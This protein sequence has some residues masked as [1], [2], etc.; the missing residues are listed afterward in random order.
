MHNTTLINVVRGPIVESSHHG[1]IVGMDF[2]GKLLFHFGHYDMVTFARSSAKLLQA[3]PVIESG[4]AAAFGLTPAEIAVL[5]ASHNGEEEHVRTVSGLLDKLGLS[6]DALQCGAH[7]PFYAPA[8]E[9][10]KERGEKPCPLHNNC[11]GK[12]SGML[13]LARHLG[14]PI[15]RYMEPSHPVQQAM[16]R[17][18]SD[19]AGLPPERILLGTDGCGVPVFGMPLCN[20]AAAYAQLGRPDRLP[21]ER[22]AACR[23][24]TDAIKSHPFLIAG[25]GR[26]DSALIE[27]THGR[28]IGKLGAEGV[29]AIAV[30][31]AGIGI[32][33]K[34]EDGNQR[35][36]Y[37]AAVETLKQTGLISEAELGLLARFHRPE[38]NNWA[39]THVG[40]IEP[41]F[42]LSYAPGVSRQSLG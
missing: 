17:T 23:A 28:I 41:V 12:H 36:L 34:V 3:I 16:L 39:G 10:M 9:Q 32:A 31:E 24:V 11:S 27:A 20:L 21:A 42:E 35:A 40:S 22:A 30:P 18:V 5:C 38:I 4:A 6:Q 13:A 33:I 2:H 14:A 25:T 37:P 15:D 8:A 19:L 7:Y 26:F 1:H 29:F